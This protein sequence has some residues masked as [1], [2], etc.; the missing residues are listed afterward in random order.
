MSEIKSYPVN[1]DKL[2]NNVLFCALQ[3]FYDQCPSDDK[4]MFL[5]IINGKSKMSLRIIDWFITNYTKK[6]NII[7]KKTFQKRNAQ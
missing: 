4:Q 7:Y 3:K 5:D 6:F 2:K 1:S